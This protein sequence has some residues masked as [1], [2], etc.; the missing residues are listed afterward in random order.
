MVEQGIIPLLETCASGFLVAHSSRRIA[1]E[2]SPKFPEVP[3]RNVARLLLDDVIRHTECFVNIRQR[4][5]TAMTY[6]GNQR[7][8]LNLLCS[9][10]WL[11]GQSPRLGSLLWEGRGIPPTA[12]ARL[13]AGSSTGVVSL[14]FPAG[15]FPFYALCSSLTTDTGNAKQVFDILIHLYQF[16]VALH[17]QDRV[18][19]WCALRP[20]PN[21]IATQAGSMS[22][23]EQTVHDVVQRLQDG[24]DPT[25][26]VSQE[27]PKGIESLPIAGSTKSH[28]PGGISLS[29]S[30]NGG[31]NAGRPVKM[32]CPKVPI[33]RRFSPTLAD[34]IAKHHSMQLD[35][36]ASFFLQ[37]NSEQG[38][39][40]SGASL[41]PSADDARAIERAIR[42]TIS[43]FGHQYFLHLD[44]GGS[45][46]DWQEVFSHMCNS[47]L[48]KK[49]LSK[50]ALPQL[51]A[52]L[53]LA[54]R[55]E[56][57][58]LIQSYA[59]ALHS[60]LTVAT[61][62]PVSRIVLSFS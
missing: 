2:G 24:L 42:Q 50:V 47:T 31:G 39:V 35:E 18:D 14:S 3:I 26:L 8:R 45:Y 58:P 56:M 46:T 41:R 60:R 29:E 20:L 61:I 6:S 44:D 52:C 9:V 59:E 53:A 7:L 43:N 36:A 55:Y 62:L 12:D 4:L 1:A 49:M 34:A 21:E 27:V 13:T 33:I 37:M 38:L 16:A 22:I 40:S 25:V 5:L 17:E 57:E 19:R 32:V 15:G 51:C 28:R 54:Y 23:L 48:R 10:L 11:C 30:T